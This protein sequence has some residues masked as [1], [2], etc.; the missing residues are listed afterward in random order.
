MKYFILLFMIIG[1][2]SCSTPP[3]QPVKTEESPKP[4]KPFGKKFFDYDQIDHY[5]K[6][7]ENADLS[8]LLER[9]KLTVLDSLNAGALLD[10]LAPDLSDT[11]FIKHLIKAGF[12]KKKVDPSNFSKID[13]VFIEKEVEENSTSNCIYIYRDILV[14]KKRNRT[15]G[16]AKICFECNA[17]QISGTTANTENFGQDGDYDKLQK[18]LQ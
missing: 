10:K 13:S 18:L 7:F 9:Q 1:W 17:H 3:Q 5:H 6:E 16:V 2:L 8:R 12:E 4:V 14:F 11:P 15:I